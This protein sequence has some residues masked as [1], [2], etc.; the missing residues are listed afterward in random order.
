MGPLEQHRL[1]PCGDYS[2]RKMEYGISMLAERDGYE[3]WSLNWRRMPRA[4]SW[5]GIPQEFSRDRSGGRK[6][7]ISIGGKRCSG[8]TAR[9]REVRHSTER[10]R[11]RCSSQLWPI[12]QA[13][14]GARAARCRAQDAVGE[15]TIPG[16]ISVSGHH[17]TNARR[18]VGQSPR[19]WR[20]LSSCRA[21]TE[22]AGD[23]IRDA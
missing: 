3:G 4:V 19:S 1:A 11:G 10:F 12:W 9:L 13:G 15:D 23:E 18:M 16:V 5:V 17:I 8:M 2:L 6:M 21:V 7:S 14:Q 22:P 20:T